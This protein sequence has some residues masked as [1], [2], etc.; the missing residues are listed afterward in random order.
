MCAEV[1]RMCGCEFIAA[2]HSTQVLSL[3]R[4]VENNVYRMAGEVRFA[5]PGLQMRCGNG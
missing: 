4:R 1:V 2:T 5:A 3:T